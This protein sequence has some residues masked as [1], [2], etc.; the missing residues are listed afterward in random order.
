MNIISQEPTERRSAK[1]AL[2]SLS[3]SQVASV[4]E[5]SLD[6]LVLHAQIFEAIVKLGIGHMDAQLL[7]GFRILRV[8]VEPHLRQPVE[9]LG[10]GHTIL[11][12]LASNTTL[13]NQLGDLEPQKGNNV[14]T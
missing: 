8:E 1:P 2:K 3:H 10:A 9:G 11:Q 5:R 14:N 6:Q 7:Q 13:M 12:Q 4:C